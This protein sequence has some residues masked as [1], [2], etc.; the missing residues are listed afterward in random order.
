METKKSNATTL[1]E[2]EALIAEARVAYLEKRYWTEKFEELKQKLKILEDG[3]K[4][5]Q[6]QG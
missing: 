6:M 4:E 5:L 2:I 3:N 1:N